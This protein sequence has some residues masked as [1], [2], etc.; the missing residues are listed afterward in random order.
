MSPDFA[1]LDEST[2]AAFREIGEQ[3]R[4]TGR[5]PRS[6]A[7]ARGLAERHG[8][9]PADVCALAGFPDRRASAP[10]RRLA[11]FLHED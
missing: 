7:A 11:K 8:A 4:Q 10:A 9:P 1:L 6:R 2:R 3:H 5:W